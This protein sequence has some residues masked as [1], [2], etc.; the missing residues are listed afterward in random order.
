MNTI[1][2]FNKALEGVGSK[3]D[4]IKL[5]K[6][7]SAGDGDDIYYCSGVTDLLVGYFVKKDKQDAVKKSCAAEATEKTAFPLR[8]DTVTLFMKTLNAFKKPYLVAMDHAGNVAHWA[9]IVG[10]PDKN[11]WAFYQ[12]NISAPKGE[13]ITVAPAVNPDTKN[14][15]KNELDKAKLTTFLT[16]ITDKNLNY[17]HF[18]FPKAK[19]PYMTWHMRVYSFEGEQ[20]LP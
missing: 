20:L 8:K 4:L 10:M 13:W 2:T 11:Q 15:C 6:S 18:P 1:D 9:G 12:A 7:V 16:E 17:Q 3:A 19:G 14:W 5:Y